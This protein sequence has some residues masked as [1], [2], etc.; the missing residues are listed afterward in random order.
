MQG[1]PAGDTLAGA[2]T[3]EG[4][5]AQQPPAAPTLSDATSS[6]QVSGAGSPWLTTSQARYANSDPTRHGISLMAAQLPSEGK[7][8]TR[9]RLRFLPVLDSLEADAVEQWLV[10][11]DAYIASHRHHPPP[12]LL[13]S[14]VGVSGAA[15]DFVARMANKAPAS[16]GFEGGYAAL[17][18]DAELQS[19]YV[20]HVLTEHL[21]SSGVGTP[22]Q[23][24]DGLPMITA[25]R[26]PSAA[27][28]HLTAAVL[29]VRQQ[30]RRH[31]IAEVHAFHMAILERVLSSLPPP[32]AELLL[33]LSHFKHPYSTPTSPPFHGESVGVDIWHDFLINVL[34]RS[35]TAIEKPRAL[36]GGGL[37]LAE[38]DIIWNALVDAAAVKSGKRSVVPDTGGRSRG[39][40]GS[41]AQSGGFRPMCPDVLAG[42]ACSGGESCARDHYHPRSSP[43]PDSSGRSGK[44]PVTAGGGGSPHP[45]AAPAAPGVCF[46]FASGKPCPGPPDCRR[47]HTKLSDAA[48]AQLAQSL[49]YD[50]GS[51]NTRTAGGDAAGSGR[52]GGGGGKAVRFN[53]ITSGDQPPTPYTDLPLD[54]GD[55]LQMHITLAGLPAH[56]LVDSCAGCSLMSVNTYN[57]LAATALPGLR[58]SLRQLGPSSPSSVTSSSGTSMAVLGATS[59]E[60]GYFA[61][62]RRV[63]EDVDRALLCE[64]RF[65]M[66]DVLVVDG[67]DV[68][69]TGRVL[70]IGQ[71]DHALPPLAELLDYHYRLDRPSGSREFVVSTTS[72]AVVQPAAVDIDGNIVVPPRLLA[73]TASVADDAVDHLD[74]LDDGE[75]VD[76]MPSLR[77]N[78]RASGSSASTGSSSSS[79]SRASSPS[80][81]SSS[82]P[83]GGARGARAV[84]VGAVLAAA[85]L[86][87]GLGPL[88]PL[89]SSVPAPVFDVVEGL[90]TPES[91]KAAAEFLVPNHAL[92]SPT[93]R[94]DFIDRVILPFR[95]VLGADSAALPS[96][97]PST[98]TTPIYHANIGPSPPRVVT[99][100]Y[101]VP[102]RHV[103]PLRAEVDRYVRAGV[104]RKAPRGTPAY[105]CGYI[106]ETKPGKFRLVGDWTNVNASLVPNSAVNDRLNK[107][108]RG[109]LYPLLGMEVFSSLDCMDGYTGIR[110]D[111]ETSKWLAIRILDDVY[112]VD[113]S[114][115]GVSELPGVF[116]A[117]YADLIVEAH[118]MASS[119]D[120]VASAQFIDDLAVGS[121]AANFEYHIRF[122][123]ALF[124][125]FRREG[126]R[127]RL[128]KCRFLA[129]SASYC[130]MVV[131]GK[132]IDIERSRVA[133][134]FNMP[135]PRS[136][137]ALSRAL[138]VCNYFAHVVPPPVY[139]RML[140]ATSPLKSLD[141][142]DFVRAWSADPGIEKSFRDVLVAITTNGVTVIPDLTRPIYIRSDAS[143]LYGH[144][145]CLIQFD[146][147]TGR[148]GLIAYWSKQWG[149]TQTAWS[150]GRKEAYGIY[151]AVTRIA[152]RF[153]KGAT[154]VIDEIDA[155]NLS[156]ILQTGGNLASADPHIRRWFTYLLNWQFNFN[157]PLRIPGKINIVA[158]A[159]S[160]MG[161]NLELSSPLDMVTAGL[162]ALVESGATAARVNATRS[163]KGATAGDAGAPR[164]PPSAAAAPA[165][166]LP[167]QSDAKPD[168]STSSSPPVGTPS[169]VPGH[170]PAASLVSAVVEA[171]RR[172]PPA[173][174]PLSS[175][176]ALESVTIPGVGDVILFNNS[177]FVP[178]NAASI[179]QQLIVAAHDHAGHPGVQYTVEAL[180]KAHV[181]WPG[182]ESDVRTFI[183]SCPECQRFKAP[184]TIAKTGISE[185]TA[186][187]HPYHTLYVD[188]IGPLSD[189][190]G[191]VLVI[192]DRFSGYMWLRKV[193]STAST[194]LISG[195]QPIVDALGAPRVLRVDRAK[196]N[197]SKQFD[198]YAQQHGVLLVPSPAHAHFTLGMVEGRNDTIRMLAHVMFAPNG[199]GAAAA[200]SD[201]DKLDEL[202]SVYN[203]TLNRSTGFTPFRLFRGYDPSTALSTLVGCE[204]VPGNPNVEEY[205]HRVN[206]MQLLASTGS[207]VAQFVAARDR[208][209]ARSPPP[210]FGTGDFVL[211]WYPPLNKFEP[212]YR[213]P[214]IIDSR[215]TDSWYYVRRLVDK[216][217]TNAV[218]FEV[219]VSRLRKFNMSRTDIDSLLT[220]NLDS[221]FGIVKG[222][223]SHRA[224]ADGS[225]EFEVL[226][227]DGDVTY[228]PPELLSKVKVFRDYVESKHI[229][230]GARRARAPAPQRG[231]RGRRGAA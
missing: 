52:G 32:V 196:G 119:I 132:T 139:L 174:R 170:V 58:P 35:Q 102:Q 183:A 39:Q 70:V 220:F 226:W 31:P 33:R 5:D 121:T 82:G 75:D 163:G 204:A 38:R 216:H 73:T 172:M 198:K 93:Q 160:R 24:L 1:P 105:A 50:G 153:I 85:T 180:R 115:F 217:N 47:A 104:L 203:A 65:D 161:E 41:G 17:A 165:A 230:L 20:L 53:L 79:S 140:N 156:S 84:F 129:D 124:T 109:S 133:D 188:F 147:V 205:A 131:N 107:D 191:Y 68:G 134:L 177:I 110:N 100:A 143:S 69:L 94:A 190:G 9:E 125:L 171:Q 29:R 207:N 149:P 138:G 63:G 200:L 209:A 154:F 14:P 40:G 55:S 159:A 214:F 135:S 8:A 108:M 213:G 168:P 80:S 164:A 181:N 44:H 90:Y 54:Q 76:S 3:R 224:L 113:R 15:A 18:R 128:S 208:D 201:Q 155:H 202:A 36:G 151:Y 126:W 12:F 116:H 175:S 130:G 51:S 137:R 146:P 118:D 228:S 221:S 98:A 152:D 83:R 67:L 158:D 22:L 157:F 169:I 195:L 218:P 162:S 186:A 225:L 227:A 19:A 64:R 88:P 71:P 16:G 103:Q 166:H 42:K 6:A 96:R 127:V 148:P 7:G 184:P 92:L 48:L 142:A 123:E 25:Q 10:K 91:I 99:H 87:T 23:S 95:D 81:S 49:G 176:G 189:K 211:V 66:R 27:V 101:S 2:T 194:D 4:L 141:S 199:F 62:A 74:D 187:T 212:A 120:R 37:P 97:I 167:A 30:L 117:S 59:V 178:P 192:I 28:A 60:V 193:S 179:R 145:G 45:A 78:S 43:K 21:A 122:L 206:M 13:T 111:D 72:W 182:R 112:F 46:R 173:E 223:K 114:L 229:D 34:D 77:S 144:G 136:A 61:A 210:S 150:P 185:P 86:A 106:V 219:H 231:R 26:S 56:A 222:I 197:I 215:R 57:E 89:G 11:A